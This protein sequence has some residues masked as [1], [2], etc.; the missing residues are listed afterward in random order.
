MNVATFNGST[1]SLHHRLTATLLSA[2]A[3]TVLCA[4][5]SVAKAADT[6]S[7]ASVVVRF[8]DLDLRSES[9]AR[10]LYRRIASAVRQVCPET[11][12]RRLGDKAAAWSCQR[13][14]LDQAVASINN[15]QVAMLLKNPRLA[16]AR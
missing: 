1:T 6:P 7:T 9:G 5:A 14:A 8:H 2:C 12:S 10:T 16:S 15:P 11:D 4:T 13:Q 3:V